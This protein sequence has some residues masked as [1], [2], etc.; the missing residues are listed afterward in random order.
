MSAD[1]DLERRIADFYETEAPSRA[2]DWV[3]R[4]AL[5]T[6]DTTP[7]RRAVIR[8]PWRF[9]PMNTFAKVAIAAV[10]VIAVGV[11]GLSVLRPSSSSNV[12]G[13]QPTA[14][15]TT[16]PS[17]TPTFGTTIVPESPPALTETFTSDRHGFS[18]SYPAGW[19]TSAATEPWATA[20]LPNFLEPAGDFMFDPTL[21]DHLFLFIGSKP[22]AGQDGA[23]WADEFLNALAANDECALPFESVTTGAGPA[24]QCAGGGILATWTG[25]RGYVVW[26]YRSGDD[27]AAVA[28]Y[29]QA[30]FEDVVATLEL[31]PED[32]VDTPASPSPSA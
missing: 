14:S 30:F 31:R 12:G 20:G 16:S 19:D 21:T 29:D 13:G 11:V 2:P 17:P 1:R 26:L 7:Q 4:T 15:A 9:P 22:L 5:E 18:I 32:A 24:R 28:G 10:V 25:D 23:A 3:L 27:P 6:I 8:V